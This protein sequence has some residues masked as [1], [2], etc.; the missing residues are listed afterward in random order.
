MPLPGDLARRL[1]AGLSGGADAYAPLTSNTLD[2]RFH[3]AVIASVIAHMALLFGVT[4]KA[5][6]PA[7]LDYTRSLDVV[8]VNARSLSKPIRPDVLAQHHLDGG[9]DVEEERQAQSPLPASAHDTQAATAAPAAPAAP[10]EEAPRRLVEQAQSDYT[11]R[12]EREVAPEA[13]RP[14]P[15]AP[16]D[17]AAASLEQARLMARI[18]ERLD[19]S[20][21]ATRRV[22]IGARAQEF[23]HARYIEDWRL[24]VERI[25]NLNYPEAARRERIHGSLVL[26]VSI[27]ADGSLEEARISRSSGSRI[28]DAAALRILEMS[29]PFPPFSEEMRKSVDVLT[30]SRT[31]QFTTS[32][33]LQSQ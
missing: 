17:L 9:G 33:Q 26:T 12:P 24:K 10:P 4:F 13:P 27:R 23:S 18:S 14:A 21:K 28:L 3:T 20:Q 16:L 11:A 15:P 32:D 30:F 22:Y 5:A 1:R 2:N 8:L 6:N 19:A 31:W 7:L 25:G 29:A